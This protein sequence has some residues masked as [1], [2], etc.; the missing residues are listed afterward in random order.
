MSA[1]VVSR[2]SETRTLPWVCAPIAAS[3]CDGSRVLAVHADPDETA[4]PA[5]VEPGDE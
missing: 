3:T 5:A 1:S 2:P 4:K